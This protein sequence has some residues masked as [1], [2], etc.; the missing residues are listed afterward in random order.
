M[1]GI[2]QMI[3]EGASVKIHYKLSVGG[4]LVDSSEG[5]DP[6]SYVQGAG[7]IVA[8]LEKHLAK[9]RQGDRTKVTVPPEEAYGNL[10]ED[11]VQILPKDAFDSADGL[12]V[13]RMI[14]GATSDGQ[15][16]S[17][18]I[19][20]VEEDEVTLDLNHPLAGQTLVFEVEVLEVTDPEDG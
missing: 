4:R 15:A 18:T 13:G 3:R 5:R 16:F 9:M 2:T 8:G 12:E 14:Q 11:A 6:L 7:Q 1:I 10:N 17:A 19:R 20:S